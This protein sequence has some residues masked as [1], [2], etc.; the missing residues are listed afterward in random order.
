ME[1]KPILFLNNLSFDLESDLICQM[2]TDGT[3]DIR[4]FLRNDELIPCDCRGTTV[5]VNGNNIRVVGDLVRRTLTCHINAK[6]E[7]PET[8]KWDF[9]PIDKVR[10]N[11]EA[12]LV[13][14]FTIVRAYM[15]AGSPRV[16]MLRRSRALMLG[17]GWYAFR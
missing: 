12:Y 9:D 7:R 1:A 6:M 10:A 4:P 11:R 3:I 5:F 13:A 17:R 2:V 14:A 8:R 15:A 16:M